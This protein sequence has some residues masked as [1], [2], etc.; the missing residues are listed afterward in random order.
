MN[1][2]EITILSRLAMLKSEGNTGG[3]YLSILNTLD[4]QSKELG[5]MIMNNNRSNSIVRGL[6][7]WSDNELGIQ[8]QG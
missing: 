7:E 3:Y 1:E 8:Q 4:G 5:I 2:R 6:L